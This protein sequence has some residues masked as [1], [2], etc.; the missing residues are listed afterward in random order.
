MLVQRSQ[1]T[2]DVKPKK[3]CTFAP[4]C[5]VDFVTVLSFQG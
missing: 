1:I 4:I 3:S 5:Y 2:Q